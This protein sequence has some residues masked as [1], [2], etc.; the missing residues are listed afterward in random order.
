MRN[1]AGILFL[2][3]LIFGSIYFLFRRSNTRV[4]TPTPAPAPAPSPQPTEPPFEKTPQEIIPDLDL[5]SSSKRLLPIPRP[6]REVRIKIKH[7]PAPLKLDPRAQGRKKREG[8][9]MGV[10]LLDNV[11]VYGTADKATKS[12]VVRTGDMV[13]VFDNS[14]ATMAHIQP[15]LDI[16][17]AATTKE[18]KP[19][20]INLPDQD[21]WID[22]TF[23]HV[24]EP[25]DAKE[26]LL[27][28]TPITLGNDSSF[29]TLD[30]YDR[31]M[32]N[33]DPVVHRVMGPRMIALLLIH[34]DYSSSWSHLYRDSDPKIRDAALAA[35][36]DRGVAD[37]R[38]LI[39]DLIVRLT[40][41]TKVKAA[42]ETELEALSILGVLEASRHPRVPAA[43]G[44][45][46]EAW[47][48]TQGR[49]LNEALKRILKH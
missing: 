12:Y 9:P 17:L 22:K 4:T 36:N 26:F 41:L 5:P 14:T 13:R 31:A 28:T 23:L 19:A 8:L 15:G 21:G 38:E 35:L 39:E 7:S 34:E 40:E 6:P 3:I 27:E 30:F 37:N 49:E 46:V 42:G 43:M 32:N 29:S 2:L 11:P 10:V 16:Y 20:G 33:P 45:F 25:I 47:Q 1:K 18:I 44:S 24:F 48:D